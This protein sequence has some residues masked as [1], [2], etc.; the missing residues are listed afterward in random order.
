MCFVPP[1]GLYLFAH[2]CFSDTPITEGV[3]IKLYFYK[4]ANFFVTYMQLFNKSVTAY[5][6]DTMYTWMSFEKNFHDSH[7]I[8]WPFISTNVS[9]DVRACL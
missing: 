7:L 4:A 6:L 8:S 9:A 1:F 2:V 3:F 5:L